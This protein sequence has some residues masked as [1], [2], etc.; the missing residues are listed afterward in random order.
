[1]IVDMSPQRQRRHKRLIT[2]AC[3]HCKNKP[4][5]GVLIL[6]SPVWVFVDTIVE[7]LDSSDS[8]I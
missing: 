4:C 7:L 5:M 8:K 2:I 6:V 1:M 3:R